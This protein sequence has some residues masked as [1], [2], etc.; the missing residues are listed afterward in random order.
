MNRR[1]LGGA[2]LAA[3]AA[4]TGLVPRGA[5]RA[6]G[7]GSYPERPVTIVVSWAPGGSTDFVGRLLAQQMSK[8][9][10]QQVV[11]ENR[12]GA[13]GTIGHL[14]VARARADGYTL[15]MGVNSTYA[16]ATH[17]FPRRAMT[18]PRASRRSAASPR[19]RSSS[20]SGR[21][22]AS[23]RCRSWSPAPRRSRAS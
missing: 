11:V 4:S 21:S 1:Q 19:R 13:S 12:A 2:A 6:Q 16:M 22:W 15:L 7:A 10:G 20:A 5:A 3:L 8:E 23:R 17:L 18:T 9:L 14:Y